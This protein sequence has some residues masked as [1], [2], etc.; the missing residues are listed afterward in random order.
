M[1]RNTSTH[2]SLVYPT[3]DL[4][5]RLHRLLEQGHWA[6]E[7]AATGLSVD[8]HEPSHGS[9]LRGAEDLLA[10]VAVVSEHSDRDDAI[11]LLDGATGCRNR[12]PGRRASHPI[13]VHLAPG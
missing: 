12:G 5:R 4:T 7:W 13:P 9:S 10:D 1:G 2:C 8:T 6:T 11:T 3:D